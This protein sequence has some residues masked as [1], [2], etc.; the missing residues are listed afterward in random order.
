M[1]KNR[2]ALQQEP[3]VKAYRAFIKRLRNNAPNAQI[4]LTIGPM[5]TQPVDKWLNEIA[6]DTKNTA[7]LVFE[8]TSSTSE[9]I[10]S[11]MEN[12]NPNE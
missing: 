10:K 4:I 8:A 11:T 5:Q 3:Y 2:E 12:R 9:P 6:A 1:V 7:V